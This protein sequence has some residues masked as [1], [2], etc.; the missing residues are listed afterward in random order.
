MI[1]HRQ[2]LV[3]GA[4]QELT[5]WYGTAIGQT[6]SVCGLRCS[7]VEAGRLVGAATVVRHAVAALTNV[8]IPSRECTH[9]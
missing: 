1:S 6:R 2:F 7:S 9:D 5:A 4:Y 8:R 3:A